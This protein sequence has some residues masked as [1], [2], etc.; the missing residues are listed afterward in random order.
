MAQ[1]HMTFRQADLLQY[2]L[3]GLAFVTA[4]KVRE[5]TCGAVVCYTGDRSQVVEALRQF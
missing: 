2:Y 4:A 3:Q 5:K 1:P